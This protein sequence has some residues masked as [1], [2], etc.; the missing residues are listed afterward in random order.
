M[1]MSETED[2]I[3]QLNVRRQDKCGQARLKRRHQMT[4][5]PLVLFMTYERE[6][7]DAY[8]VKIYFLI[9]NESWWN[10]LTALR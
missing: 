10:R 8:L 7:D 4:P 6:S 1:Y 3:W 9:H 5:Q 2:Q